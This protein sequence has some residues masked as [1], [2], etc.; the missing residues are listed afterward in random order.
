MRKLLL[1]AL[2]SWSLD[3]LAA[4]HHSVQW[5]VQAISADG[6][7]AL[8]WETGDLPSK[9][10]FRVVE[11]ASDK[12]LQD[13][14]LPAL[15]KL[16]L[17]TVNDDNSVRSVK[18]ALDT[19]EIAA[20][21][22]AIG[23]VLAG[24]PLG[25]GGRIAAA[26]DGKHVAFNAGDWIYTAVDGK[27]AGRVANES[28]YHPWFTPDGKTLLFYRQSGMLSGVETKYELYATS[29]DGKAPVQRIAGTAEIHEQFA[30]TDKGTLR[31]VASAP[32]AIPTCAIEVQLTAP[33]RVKKLGCLPDK[34][35]TMSCVLSPKGAWF[36]CETVKE[37][38]ELDPNSTTEKADGTVVHNHKKRYR[39]RSVDAVTGKVGT[40]LIDPAS[41]SAISDSG[42]LILLGRDKMLAYDN[43]G[44]S[45]EITGGGHASLYTHFTGEHT[46]VMDIDGHP[47]VLDPA[48]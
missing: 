33:Y 10:H 30:L 48:R 20:E 41:L 7:R 38:P 36:A 8:L 31:A 35:Q 1:L 44:A 5:F 6:T 12:T 17:E 40:D 45:H 3:S 9:L 32:P 2:A 42:V 13:I 37:L 27:V 14:D 26:P 23:P 4:P 28:A 18:L 21:L 19:P 11:I 16:P 25:A 34:E 39:L 47:S 46:L 29:A 24:F 22:R 15:S 43:H